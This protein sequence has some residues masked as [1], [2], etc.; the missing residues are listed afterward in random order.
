MAKANRVSL[1]DNP[2]LKAGV[3]A[4]IEER[5]L[6]LNRFSLYDLLTSSAVICI[7]FILASIRSMKF[8]AYLL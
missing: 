4:R 6:A 3:I 5:A 7:V 8:T 1:L 2:S